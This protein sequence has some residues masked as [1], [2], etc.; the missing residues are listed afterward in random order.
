MQQ[1]ATDSPVAASPSHHANILQRINPVYAED[2]IIATIVA[3]MMALGIVS[4]WSR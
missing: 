1:N 4:G 3:A 2:E